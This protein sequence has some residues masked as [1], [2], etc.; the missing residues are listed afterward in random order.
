MEENNFYL[1]LYTRYEINYIK[2]TVSVEIGLHVTYWLGSLVV[3][4]GALPVPGSN[5]GPV[6]LCT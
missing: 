4:A 5:P 1:G 2:L 3:K 6:I